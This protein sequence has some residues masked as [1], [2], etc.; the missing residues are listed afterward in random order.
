MAQIPMINYPAPDTRNAD[1]SRNV[2]ARRE[3]VCPV[4]VWSGTIAANGTAT[5]DWITT[6]Q[7]SEGTLFFDTVGGV[8][9][10]ATVS[11]L[12]GCD[13]TDNEYTLVNAAG[14]AINVT[15]ITL[16]GNAT[17][18]YAIQLPAIYWNKVKVKIV[19]SGGATLIA[20]S[21]VRLGARMV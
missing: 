15:A 21:Q 14:A 19:L 1:G 18:R 5:S 13:I 2:R 8:A 7:I 12:G 3:E 10:T 17:A 11:L 20:G 4:A 9:G 16:A 6:G